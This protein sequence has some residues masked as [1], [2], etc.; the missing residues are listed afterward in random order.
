MHRLAIEKTGEDAYARDLTLKDAAT[1][2]D[3]TVTA[4]GHLV[5]SSG[6]EVNG[7]SIVQGGTKPTVHIYSGGI[8]R[9]VTAGGGTIELFP[10]GGTIENVTVNNGVYLN[11]FSNGVVDGGSF[12]GTRLQVGSKAGT[13]GGTIRNITILNAA[14][15]GANRVQQTGSMYDCT[16]AA[17]AQYAVSGG[18]AERTKVN[19]AGASSKR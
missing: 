6:A 16:I 11:V 1:A 7:L 17:G 9:N 18:L 10:Y 12:S 19:G 3:L 2:T 15:D 8:A 14:A 5:V 4:A 13:P